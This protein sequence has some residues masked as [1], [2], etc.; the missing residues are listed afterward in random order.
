ERGDLTILGESTV[1]GFRKGLGANRSLRRLFHSVE[2][3]AADTRATHAILQAVAAEEDAEIS[4]AV[5]ERLNEL[6]DYFSSGTVQPGRSVGLL[7]KV[8][9]LAEGRAGP[10]TEHD[11]LATLSSSTGIP[12]DFLDDAVALDRAAVRQ[13]FETRVM[14]QPEAVEAV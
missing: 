2:L 10:I 14:G 12:T 8:L 5:L 7:R 6:A 13:F 3:A 11:I 1:E 4:D 9:G